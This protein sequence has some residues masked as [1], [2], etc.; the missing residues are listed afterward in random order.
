MKDNLKLRETEEKIRRAK[1]TQEK[2]EREKKE[3]MARKKALVD[4]NAGA[5][6]GMSCYL[7]SVYQWEAFECILIVC[8]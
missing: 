2:R 4:M 5:C 3:K 1:E 7:R 6:L 8:R